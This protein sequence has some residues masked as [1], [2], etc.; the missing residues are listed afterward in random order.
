MEK[1]K[2]FV[3]ENRL[4]LVIGLCLLL[5]IC[6]LH[7]DARRNEPIYNDTDTNVADLEKRIQSAE[8]RID[9]MSKRIE[10]A[11]KAVESIGR[12]ISTSTGLTYQIIEGTGRA[13]KRL[14][15]AIQRSERIQNII[16][17]IERSD[18]ERKKNP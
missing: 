5:L 15:S 14:E 17:D 10:V 18:R 2:E 3:A 12:G 6:W 1:I 9:G 11:E 8:Q 16:S 4:I 13:E 7:H